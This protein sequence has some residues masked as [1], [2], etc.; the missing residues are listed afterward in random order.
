MTSAPPTTAT[1]PDLVVT[2]HERLALAGFPPATEAW[3][4]TPTP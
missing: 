2:D 4:G 3:P 1:V